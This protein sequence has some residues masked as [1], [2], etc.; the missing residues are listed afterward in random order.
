[1]NK[2]LGAL[3]CVTLSLVLIFGTTGCPQ[4]DKDK[5]PAAKDAVGSKDM[6][7][8]KK[9]T[10]KP[11]TDTDKPKTDTDKPKTDTDKPK[12]DTDKPKTDTDKPKTDT[13]KPKTDTDKPKT[14]KPKTDTDKP[15]KDASLL[16]P[17]VL[18]LYALLNDRFFAPMVAIRTM[19][20]HAQLGRAGRHYT[21]VTA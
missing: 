3:G 5:K 4:K 16:S 13:D 1:M 19:E 6:G 20:I 10:D 8:D 11:K 2:L 21:N 9:D 12:T 15:K 17:E 18:N 14:D 7:K